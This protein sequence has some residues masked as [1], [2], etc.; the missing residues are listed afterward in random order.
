[1]LP[2]KTQRRRQ[3]LTSLR[4]VHS[5]RPS[6]HQRRAPC[7]RESPLQPSHLR[8][9]PGEA[10]PGEAAPGEAEPDNAHLQAPGAAP[11]PAKEADT[12]ARPDPAQTGRQGPGTAPPC[13]RQGQVTSGQARPQLLP[14]PPSP[15]HAEHS[16]PRA[17]VPLAVTRRDPPLLTQVLEARQRKPFGTQHPAAAASCPLPP[18]PRR[19]TLPAPRGCA[20]RPAGNTPRAARVPLCQGSAVP[21]FRAARVPRPKPSGQALPAPAPAPLPP[22]PARSERTG[23]GLGGRE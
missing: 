14:Q 7:T 11:C 17:R 3:Q 4:P 21:G 18:F 23:Q 22:Q 6:G 19:P 1:M 12:E 10:E 13:P 9:A 20:A 16:T 15:P 5:R 2:C 8:G